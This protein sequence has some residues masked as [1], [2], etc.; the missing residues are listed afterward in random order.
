MAER[1]SER[2]GRRWDDERRGNDR[3]WGYGSRA[4]DYSRD[5]RGQ[6][7]RGDDRGFFDRAGDEVRSWF[8]DEE[9]QRRRMMDERED[10]RGGERRDWGSRE[11]RGRGD[12][13]FD[14]RNWS[15]QWGYVEGRGP[16]GGERGREWTRGGSSDWNRGWG[17]DAGRGSSG[18]WGSSGQ[19]YGGYGSYGRERDWGRESDW[20]G[21]GPGGFGVYRGTLSEQRESGGPW[22]GDREWGRFSGGEQLGSGRYS[23][24]GPRNYQRSDERIRE[25]VCE[26]L[27][28]HP[29]IDATDLD[30]RV[31]N[32]EVTLQGQVNDR[33][34][35]RW[36]EDVAEGIWGVKEV[37]NQIRVTQ[38]L[39]AQEHREGQQQE[40]QRTQQQ[41]QQRGPWA[42]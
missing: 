18:G 28:H 26:R 41:Q 22:R 9:A 25:E 10:Y 2:G 27:A 21:Q 20:G 30:I 15:R 38:I 32:G 33:W 1:Y 31:Q 36:A 37:H 12:W 3:E 23:G 29:D 39:S 8:G 4:G 13:D 34:A 7:R 16:G 24:R 17:S 11:Y 42:A 6:E 19:G 40:G 14:P 35:K 5:Y